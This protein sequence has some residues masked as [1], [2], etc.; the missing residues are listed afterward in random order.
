[1]TMLPA[2]EAALD[3][4]AR[5]HYGKRRRS[6]RRA[7]LPVIT[8]AGVGVAVLALPGRTRGRGAAAGRS[9]RLTRDACALP[10]AHP[11]AG[12]PRPQRND[13]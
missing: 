7:L 3:E 1:M 4:A 12:P 10:R 8:V 11:G 9:T 13:P 6:S 5:R 2:L